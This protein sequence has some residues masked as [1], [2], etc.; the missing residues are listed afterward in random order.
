MTIIDAEDTASERRFTL[1]LHAVGTHV[2][3]LVTTKVELAVHSI[4]TFVGTYFINWCRCSIFTHTDRLT[5][6]NLHVHDLG[7]LGAHASLL[8]RRVMLIEE[9]LKKLAQLVVVGLVL[10]SVVEDFSDEFLKLL[11]TFGL[12]AQVP[13]LVGE[14]GVADGLEVLVAVS[15]GIDIKLGQLTL[16]DEVNEKIA[17]RNQVISAASRVELQLVSAR[18]DHVAAEHVNFGL[19]N[20]DCLV[21]IAVLLA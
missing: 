18:E 4:F 10:E 13:H 12:I 7:V 16:T 8:R 11:G 1:L 15:L 19:A 20:V 14:F 9:D 3:N 17:Q 21:G 5:G 2:S 6:G